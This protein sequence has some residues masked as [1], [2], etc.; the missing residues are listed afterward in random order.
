MTD[1]QIITQCRAIIQSHLNKTQLDYVQSV[2]KLNKLYDTAST[3]FQKLCIMTAHR[4]LWYP[5]DFTLV[6]VFDDLGN[7]I[8]EL[9]QSD[10]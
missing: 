8:D 6:T 7:D 2:S 3:N 10:S 4:R 9:Y 5:T 1:S